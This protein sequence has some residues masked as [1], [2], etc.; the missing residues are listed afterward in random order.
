M[1]DTQN[2]TMNQGSPVAA[3]ARVEQKAKELVDVLV[4]TSMKWASLSLGASRKTLTTSARAL[5]RAA[6]KI[7]EIEKKLEK[8]P[9]VAPAEPV[10]AAASDAA[11]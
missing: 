7:G 10:N 1:V 8:T 4:D 11:S 2:A 6:E 9:E 3:S 5:D